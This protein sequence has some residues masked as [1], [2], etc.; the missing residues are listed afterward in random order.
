MAQMSS[1]Q[2]R[3]F[4]SAPQWKGLLSHAKR[5]QLSGCG[6]KQFVRNF[7]QWSLKL[8]ATAETGE[9][10]P[11]SE[12]TWLWFNFNRDGMFRWMCVACHTDS[13]LSTASDSDNSTQTCQLSNLQY[14]NK[15]SAH[16]LRLASFLGV[17]DAQSAFVPPSKQLFKEVL[18]AFRKG[19]LSLST[20]MTR[21]MNPKFQPHFD[22]A[23]KLK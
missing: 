6:C 2:R 4:E 14:H 17:K 1:G 20:R 5:C 23:G 21:M 7:E 10:E 19:R 9:A 18:A 3:W 12:D 8:Q 16:R 11:R 13:F 15:S 22:F